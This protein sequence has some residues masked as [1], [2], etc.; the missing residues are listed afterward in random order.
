MGR[1]AAT[2]SRRRAPPLVAMI[3]IATVAMITD[4]ETPLEDFPL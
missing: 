3:F 2:C 1:T 4:F